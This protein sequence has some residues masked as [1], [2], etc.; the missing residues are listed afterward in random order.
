MTQNIDSRKRT[1][2]DFFLALLVCQQKKTNFTFRFESF[3]SLSFFTHVFS[4]F[5]SCAKKTTLI[6]RFFPLFS[7]E[8][9]YNLQLG[10]KFLFWLISTDFVFVSNLVLITFNNH[11]SMSWLKLLNS[12]HKFNFK[13]ILLVIT[14]HFI[15]HSQLNHPLNNGT[16]ERWWWLEWV[17]KIA[18][19]LK[20]LTCFCLKLNWIELTFW[21]KM[22]V[23]VRPFAVVVFF[24]SFCSSKGRVFI[25]F[26]T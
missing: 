25:S 14:I 15:I 7:P 18:R 8:I 23:L 17:R 6:K 13:D 2:S 21:M 5:F 12:R 9:V 11:S 24:G 16:V 19:K 4:C 26:S 1:F 22:D 10:V 20:L 3:F